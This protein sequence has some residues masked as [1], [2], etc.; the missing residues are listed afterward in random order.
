[1][2]SFDND[3]SPDATSGPAPDVIALAR[4]IARGNTV[5]VV[6]AGLSIAPGCAER[7]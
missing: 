3:P 6:V 1:M 2:T 4:A 5:L 7:G